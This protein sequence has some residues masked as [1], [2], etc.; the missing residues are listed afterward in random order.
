MHLGVCVCVC[1]CVCVYVFVE[2]PTDLSSVINQRRHASGE[3]S[4]KACKDKQPSLCRLRGHTTTCTSHAPEGPRRAASRAAVAC[5]PAVACA[6]SP[7]WHAAHVTAARDA[8]RRRSRAPPL[9]RH[10]MITGA[11]R[12]AP[13]ASRALNPSVYNSLRTHPA[14]P[15][16]LLPLPLLRFRDS[17]DISGGGRR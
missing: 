4:R 1:V 9:H 12:R 2:N 3:H 11:R 13:R 6:L 7:L 14:Q 8:A 5:A 16:P 17:K 10:A 15:P